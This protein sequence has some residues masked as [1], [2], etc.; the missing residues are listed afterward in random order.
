MF[1]LNIKSLAIVALATI[2]APCF[3]YSCSAS[4]AYENGR[5]SLDE[6]NRINGAQ[7]GVAVKFLQKKEGIGFD[8]ALKEVMQHGTSPEIRSRDAQLA[9][10][11]EKIQAMKPQSEDECMALLELQHQYGEL[12]RQKIAL[13][14][15]DVTG[16]DAS[17]DK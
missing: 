8:A 10:V 7:L 16:Q 11:A 2:A 4:E 9:E 15:K 17:S 14:V 6:L 1:V 13:I 3:A 5:A 12:G